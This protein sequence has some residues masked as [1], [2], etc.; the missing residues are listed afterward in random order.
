MATTKIS[1]RDLLELHKQL[2]VQPIGSSITLGNDKYLIEQA[3]ETK[4]PYIRIN[5]AKLIV[6]NPDKDSWFAKRAKNG[7]RISWLI[8]TS[9]PWIVLY[10][11]QIINEEQIE[12]SKV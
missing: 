9:K 1:K 2:H 5:D 11:N 3:K 10:E 8:R 7:S 6:Q 12:E 4:L